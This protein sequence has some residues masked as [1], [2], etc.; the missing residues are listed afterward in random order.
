MTGLGRAGDRFFASHDEGVQPDFLCLAKGLTG[1]YL[2]MAATLTTQE[3][4]D[5]FLGEYAEFKTFFHGHS[6]TGNALG[7]A[8]SLASI[9]LLQTKATT[10][11]RKKLA[12][13]LRTEAK[14]LWALPQVGDIR[15]A[16][17]VLAVELVRDWRTRAPFALDE[18]AGIRVCNGLAKRGVLTRPVGNVIVVMPSFCTTQR[19]VK[20]IFT[21]LHDSI[22]E[23][24]NKQ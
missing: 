19:Q 18:Q 17:C 5:E 6:Y 14:R 3:I 13:N 20:K 9:E 11:K 21:A 8:A 7:S 4:F 2:P 16:G 10:N 12:T 15:Q 24:L 23:S 1:G 22:D